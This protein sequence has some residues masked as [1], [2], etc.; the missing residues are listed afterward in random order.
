MQAGARLV[1]AYEEGLYAEFGLSEERSYEV[2]KALVHFRQARS[3]RNVTK[4]D[5][6]A[7]SREVLGVDYSQAAKA[8]AS[9]YTGLGDS[10]EELI[11]AASAKNGV[12]PEHMSEILDSLL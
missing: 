10:G 4:G 5:M 1:E 12:S 9:F 6:E 8:V 11:E 7:L 2:A 3:M